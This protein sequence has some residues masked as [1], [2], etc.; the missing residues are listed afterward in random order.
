MSEPPNISGPVLQRPM[1]PHRRIRVGI[2]Y[3]WGHDPSG[4]S[5]YGWDFGPSPFA[6]PS[7]WKS[8]IAND[9]TVFRSLGI[10]AVRWFI[11]ADGTNYGTGREPTPPQLP[12]R[13]VDDFE[14]LLREFQGRQ[15]KLVPS[16]IDFHWCARAQ[17]V[18]HQGRVVGIKGGRSEF[19][20]PAN[21]VTL[22]DRV[23]EPLLNASNRYPGTIYAW[24]LMNEPEPCIT[25]SPEGDARHLA[26]IPQDEMVAFIEE[27]IRRINAAALRANPNR[28]AFESTVGYRRQETMVNWTG[29]APYLGVTQRQFHYY[30]KSN[31]SLPSYDRRS[32]PCFIG[33]FSTNPRFEGWSEL[34][35]DTI[36]RRLYLIEQRGYPCAFLWAAK[37]WSRQDQR[38]NW[39][40][41]TQSPPAQ[42][43]PQYDVWRYTSG[44]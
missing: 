9:L 3:P 29:S 26:T 35:N 23:L 20:R 4:Q 39:P 14:D 5:S 21:R 15:M 13:F 33:E 27:G 2:N 22:F 24:E 38:S 31:E 36:Y 19:L 16:L 8:N 43:T 25:G 18:L 40:Q 10:F 11:L 37:P 34:R 44:Q 41:Q 28:R 6:S 12:A 30:P 17:E 1:I 42:N 7:L 32:P